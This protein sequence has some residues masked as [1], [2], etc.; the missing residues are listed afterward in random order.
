LPGGDIPEAVEERR[1]ETAIDAT[2]VH[3]HG[4]IG[5][6]TLDPETI[7]GLESGIRN[8]GRKKRIEPEKQIYV[9]LNE[10]HSDPEHLAHKHRLVSGSPS[11]I[12][13]RDKV[14]FFSI[15][16]VQVYKLLSL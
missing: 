6:E 8:T 7:G 10:D 12:E 4:I 15:R 9:E 3:S 1:K 13:H 5:G 14:N 16:N 11:T 2:N